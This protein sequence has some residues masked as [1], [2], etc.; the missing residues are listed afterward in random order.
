[1][2]HKAQ[3]NSPNST[4][5]AG[6]RVRVRVSLEVWYLV[7]VLLQSGV[8]ASSGLVLVHLQLHLPGSL[9]HVQT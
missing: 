1:M 5:Q 2:H 8:R 6:V 9:L 3:R 7:V 4:S